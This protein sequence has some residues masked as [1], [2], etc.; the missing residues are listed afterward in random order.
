MIQV[1]GVF[2]PGKTFQ[3][4]TLFVGKARSLPLSLAPERCFTCVGSRLTCKHYA[5]VESLA[6][7]KH[8]SLLQKFVTYG[9][10]ILYNVCPSSTDQSLRIRDQFYKTFLRP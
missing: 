10:K 2:A 1:P 7:D 9:R 6:R 5:I 4:S 3:P 8:A